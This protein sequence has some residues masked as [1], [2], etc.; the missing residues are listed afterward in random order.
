MPILEILSIMDNLNSMQKRCKAKYNTVSMTIQATCSTSS[1]SLTKRRM[2][3][4][5]MQTPT[6]VRTVEKMEK[7]MKIRKRKSRRRRRR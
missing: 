3:S 7:R 1:E 6:V 5:L 2:T 4:N